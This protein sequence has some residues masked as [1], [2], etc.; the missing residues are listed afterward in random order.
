VA[1]LGSQVEYGTDGPNRSS[2]GGAGA[3]WPSGDRAADVDGIG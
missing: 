1:P 2:T 3:I